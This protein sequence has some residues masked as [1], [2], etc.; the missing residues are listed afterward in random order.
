MDLFYLVSVAVFFL[1]A[2]F[3]SFLNVF[4]A[5]LEPNVFLTKKERKDKKIKKL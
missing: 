5:E 3:G 4:V 1:G 2:I